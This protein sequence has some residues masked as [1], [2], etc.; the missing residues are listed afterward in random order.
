MSIR[1]QYEK[2]GALE[3]Y[4]AFGSVY[5]NPHEP[6]IADAIA[7]AVRRWPLDLANVLDLACGSG[8]VTLA[9]L[10]VSG[11][12]RVVGVD[13]YT[14]NAYY[15]RTGQIAHP[16]TFEEIAAGALEGQQYTTIVCSYALHLVEE[17]R[18]PLLMWQLVGLSRSLLVLSPHKR[19]DIHVHWN[20]HGEFI[21][22][23]VHARFYRSATP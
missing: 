11:G 16:L 19:P 17:S 14:G 20:L 9:L 18:L 12:A 21:H 8:E 6:A 2:H 5:R 7:L 22:E 23:R 4:R 1:S 15:E 10:R 13:P 3:F